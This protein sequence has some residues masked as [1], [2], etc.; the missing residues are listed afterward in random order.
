MEVQMPGC[1]VHAKLLAD[2]AFQEIGK[3]KLVE[4]TRKPQLLSSGF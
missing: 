3:R 4:E 2:T 1:G